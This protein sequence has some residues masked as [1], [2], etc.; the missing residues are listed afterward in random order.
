MSENNKAG[1]SD[2]VADNKYCVACNEQYSAPDWLHCKLC[3]NVIHTACISKQ[4]EAA[5]A[6]HP[7]NGIAWLYGLLN[8]MNFRLVC[9]NCIAR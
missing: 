9:P 8:S 5:G 2:Q 7:K 1:V 6:E 4:Y 3:E